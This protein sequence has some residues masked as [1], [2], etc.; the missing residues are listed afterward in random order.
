MH[1]D[2]STANWSMA[3]LR[4]LIR[5]I[6]LEYHDCLRLELP[7]VGRRM[8]QAPAAQ[9]ALR[10]LREAV[11]ANL[12][13]QEE[14]LFPAIR[15]C[16]EAADADRPLPAHAASAIRDLIP[17]MKQDQRRLVT[18]LD[19]VREQAGD[20]ELPELKDLEAD[21]RVHIQLEDTILFQRALLLVSQGR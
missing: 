13:Q 17:R 19:N 18:L 9:T 12:G 21:L 10:T 3:P 4:E 14:V 2:L 5:Y 8:A 11:D 20:D 7:A 15:N 6:V 16:E 1:G